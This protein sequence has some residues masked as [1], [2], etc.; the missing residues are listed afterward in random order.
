[1]RLLIPLLCLSFTAPFLSLPASAQVAHQPDPVQ[2]LVPNAGRSA[3]AVVEAFHRSL[4]VGNIEAASALLASNALIYESGEVEHSKAEYASHHLPA[5]AAFAKVTTR[6]V[7][8]QSGNADADMAWIATES[9]T[10]GSYKGRAIDSASTETMV[11]RRDGNAW[12]IV[13]IHWSS[14]K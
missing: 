3:A 12:K 5:D 6:K 8:R 4:K 11:L 1:M 9:R 10:T 2:S 14:W 7:T 13:H